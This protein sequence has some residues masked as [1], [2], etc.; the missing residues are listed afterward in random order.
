LRRAVIYLLLAAIVGATGVAFWVRGSML[1][2][3]AEAQDRILT[4]QFTQ[5]LED[6]PGWTALFA[7][8]SPLLRAGASRAGEPKAT[9][10]YWL[11]QYEPL[12]ASAD[13]AAEAPDVD[14]AL[15]MIEAHAAYRRTAAAGSAGPSDDAVVVKQ[16]ERI[17]GLYAEVLKRDPSQID[18]AY[19]FEFVARR[20][21]QLAMM[22]R[23]SAQSK[24]DARAA[25]ISPLGRTLHGDRG[26]VPPGLESMEFKVIVPQPSDERQE[27]REAGSG[28]PRVRKG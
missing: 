20:R 21:N 3:S 25:A 27:Q 28:A 9:S 18:A 7:P 24:S 6:G 12:D 1:A 26:A 2:R 5:A 11:G 23:G 4:L 8:L 15:L 19:N 14:S 13:A 10:Q 22:K 17:L 16:L